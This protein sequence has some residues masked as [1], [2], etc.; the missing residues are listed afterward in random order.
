MFCFKIAYS[1][2]LP[3]RFKTHPAPLAPSAP[4]S[5]GVS[6]ETI[7]LQFLPE[8]RVPESFTPSADKMSLSCKLHLVIAVTALYYN[9]KLLIRQWRDCILSHTISPVNSLMLLRHRSMSSGFANQLC[10]GTASFLSSAF[11]FFRSRLAKNP[12]INVPEIECH[13]QDTAQMIADS[14]ALAN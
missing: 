7:H 6:R 10:A 9:A 11:S 14:G 2:L 1:V 12:A 3:E 5:T 13:T 8:I 4:V